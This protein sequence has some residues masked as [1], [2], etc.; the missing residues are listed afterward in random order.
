MEIYKHILTSQLMTIEKINGN[1]ATCK[2]LIPVPSNAIVHKKF[3]DVVI[4][5]IKNL[6]KIE[7]FN[8]NLDF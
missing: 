5:N 1:I 3:N 6:E 7:D 8:E 4:C 2:L